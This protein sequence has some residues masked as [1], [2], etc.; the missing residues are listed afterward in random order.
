MWWFTRA[1]VG[2]IV[3]KGEG[4]FSGTLLDTRSNFVGRRG[5]VVHYLF[6]HIKC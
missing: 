2:A 6:I 1:W 4:K 3:R 5:E